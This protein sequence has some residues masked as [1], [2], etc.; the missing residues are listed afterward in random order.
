[1][2]SLD[3]SQLEYMSREMASLARANIPLPEGLRQ[4]ADTAA[5]SRVRAAYLRIGTAL[6]QGQSL[7]G[8][9]AGISGITSVTG[10]PAESR[11]PVLSLP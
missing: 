9:M 11:N 2:A 6:E 1:M 3:Y 5:S 7:S 8:A 4:L 10:F